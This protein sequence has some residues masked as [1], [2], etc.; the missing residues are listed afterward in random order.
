MEGFEKI[1]LGAPST[2]KTD[3]APVQAN[4]S[5]PKKKFRFGLSF[6]KKKSVFI[7]LI[8]IL[9][10]AIVMI[11]PAMKVYKSANVTYTHAKAT[12][13]AAKTQN[14]ALASTQLTQTNADLLQ[15][16]KD[17]H[18]IA[19]LKWVPIA[20]WYYND[21]DH[22]INAG[23]D[24]LAA[25]RVIVDSV[26]PYA[27]VLGLKGQGSF[28]GGTAENRIQTAVTTMGKVTPHIDDVE[29]YLSLA[30]EELDHVN[31]NHYP[32][33]FALGKARKGLQSAKDA[34][35]ATATFVSQAKPLIKVLPDLLGATSP[36]KYLIIF[37]NDKELRPTGGFITAY[38]VFNLDKGV[39]HVDRSDN[40]YN[41]DNTIS[42]KP[43]APAILQQYLRVGV[44]NLRDSN[45]SPDFLTSMDTFNSLYN[46]AGAKI[47]VDGIIA[48]DTNVLVSTI[49]I[50]DDSV[51]ADGQTFTTKIVP[52]C[53]CPQVIYS[54]ESS[55]STPLNLDYHVTD[56][57]AVNAGRKA[58]IGDLMYAILTKALKSSPKVYWGP[59][60]QDLITQ[61]S[62][63]HVLVDIYNQDAQAGVRAVN[64]DGKIIAADGDYLHINEANLGGAKSNLFVTRD[65][66]VDYKVGSDGS[67]TKNITMNFKN[68]YP[69]SD[70][71][72]ERGGLCLNATLQDWIRI[73]V[74]KGS[75]LIDS[76]GSEIKVKSYDE[77][78]KTVFEG[79]VVV[80][81]QGAATFKI[82]YKL[83]SSIKFDSTLPLLIQKQPGTYNNSYKISVNGSKRMEFPLLTDKNLTISK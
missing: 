3:F 67:V 50:L 81:T 38:S 31:P 10:F 24:G 78:G 9:I 8:V 44:L 72:L 54:L 73:Y 33:L 23:L 12:L 45:L 20:A 2:A 74:P 69:A 76:K 79:L 63:K 59:L 27:D 55:I 18:S 35:D 66:L 82:S 4:A 11:F 41:L 19:I 16:R 71:N 21:A 56:L 60:T 5:M 83:P 46:K 29:K 13:A 65:V 57:L 52:Q 42:S 28:A 32:P 68:P 7:P 15:T 48:L 37:Q 58:I 25:A 6:L 14:I 40:I 30:K 64:A 75:T 70:C 61:I 17:L 22:L 80:R 43:A 36:K 77:L 51:S 49:K 53:N 26:A 34:L 62:E 39:I 47:K 1:N